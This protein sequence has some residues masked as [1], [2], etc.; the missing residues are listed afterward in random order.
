MYID[1]VE[2]IGIEPF[3]KAVYGERARGNRAERKI[4]NG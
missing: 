2:R 1:V 4:A 3:Q